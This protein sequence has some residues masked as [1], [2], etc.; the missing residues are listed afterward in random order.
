[1]DKNKPQVT[2]VIPFYNDPYVGE[3]IESALAQ[4]YDNLE[5]IVVDDG[6]TLHA[7]KVQPYLKQIHYLGKA[8]G[9]TAS[10][11]NHGFRLAGGEYMA[12]LSSDDRYHPDKIT[13]QMEAMTRYG[14]LIGHTGF[15][16]IDASGT[17]TLEAI[18]PPGC[19]SGDLYRTLQHNNPINGCTVM[20]HKSLFRLIGP[21][22]ETLRYTH[23]LDY[24]FRVLLTGIPM[25]LTP[26]PLTDYRWHEAMGTLRHQEAIAIETASTFGKYKVRW[27]T[28]LKQ[29]G[30]I[31][32]PLYASPVVKR[33]R[34]TRK[35]D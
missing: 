24:W 35:Y 12:W 31:T 4:S 25:Q 33:N 9:G 11:L 8:N 13:K 3:A 29:L 22:D 6:S 19:E 2:I 27:D 7:D 34:K 21:F 10:A 16:R 14:A 23:D 28:Y 32:A 5:I 26:S 30:Y 18:I 1:M 17:T 20:L 15:N